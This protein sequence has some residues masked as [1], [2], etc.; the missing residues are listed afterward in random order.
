MATEIITVC[1]SNKST[2]LKLFILRLPISS[3]S[4]LASIDKESEEWS[5]ANYSK[6]I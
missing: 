3:G 1:E 5:P 4:E 6:S 2:K